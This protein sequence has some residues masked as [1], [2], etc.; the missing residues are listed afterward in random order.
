MVEYLQDRQRS[1]VVYLYF[2]YKDQHNQSPINVFVSLL[3]QLLLQLDRVPL[4][5]KRL[6]EYCIRKQQR[7]AGSEWPLGLFTN[8]SRHSFTATYILLDAFDECDSS[9]HEAILSAVKCLCQSKNVKVMLTSRPYPEI[10]LNLNATTINIS[11][12]DSDVKT[13][14]SSKLKKKIFLRQELKEE[15]VSRISKGAKG[16]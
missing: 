8:I 4:E 6:W 15:I 12:Q 7:P 5:L 14:L 9:Q 3:K 10:L 13:Y 1:A 2:D 16:M 11:A